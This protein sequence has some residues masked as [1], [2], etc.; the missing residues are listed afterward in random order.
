MS[1]QRVNYIVIRLESSEGQMVARW[2]RV[3]NA[4]GQLNFQQFVR[5]SAASCGGWQSGDV[6]KT[7]C[8]VRSKATQPPHPSGPGL[9]C[10][11]NHLRH[12]VRV[13]SS[14]TLVTKTKTRTKTNQIS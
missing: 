3:A 13:T 12:S 7:H 6:A 4:I 5:S 2:L 14:D 10:S 11:R 9:M 8:C 1:E